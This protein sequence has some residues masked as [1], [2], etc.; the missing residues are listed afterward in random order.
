[1]EWGQDIKDM[2]ALVIREPWL[3]LILQGHKT[4]E[5]RG[6][7]CNIREC[8]GLIAGIDRL[9]ANRLRK[10]ERRAKSGDAKDVTDTQGELSARSFTQEKANGL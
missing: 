1:M 3:S 2:R 6:T 9:L 4:W 7:N 8:I 10:S 5:I